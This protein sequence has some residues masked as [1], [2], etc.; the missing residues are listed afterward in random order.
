MAED[1]T[2]RKRAEDALRH[3]EKI[4]ASLLN[5]VPNPIVVTNPDG[6]VRYVNPALE[7]ITGFSSQQV[8][9]LKPPYPWWTEET[10][11]KIS[12]GFEVAFH[13]GARGL[14]ELFQNKNG[15][16]FW[17]EVTSTPVGS[18]GE[19][20]YYL[21]IWVD[22][23]ERKKAEKALKESEKKYKTLYES[24]SDAI[25]LLLPGEK[26]FTGNPAAVKL[27]GCA[28]EEE[29]T[30]Y[31]PVGFS[32]E[33]QPDG[34][35]SIVKAQQ[36]IAIALEKGS[37]F[38][39]WRAKPLKGPE[40]L[41]TISLTKMALGGKIVLQATVRDITDR[42]QAE[43]ALQ[44]SEEKY[45]SLINDVLESSAVGIFILDKEFKIVW[46]NKALGCYFGLQRDEVVGKDIRQLIREGIK[47]IFEDSKLFVEKVFATYDNNAFIEN[48]EC[49][50]VSDDEREERWLEHWS[51]P[52]QSGLYAGGR[53]EHYY[54]ISERKRAEQ[55]TRVLTQKL[56]KA[57]ESER[58][59]ISLYLHDKIAQDLS[60]L[61]I[62]FGSQP[63]GPAETKQTSSEISEVLQAVIMAVR[64]RSY[65]L[66]PPTLD[67]LG[68]VRAAY[69]YCREFSK[70]TGLRVDF[71]SAGMDNTKLDF[72]TD[73]NLYRLIQEGLNNI[74]KH[75]DASRVAVRLVA[76]FPNIILRIEDNGKGFDVKDRLVTAMNEKRMGLWSMEQR[77]SL[78][79]GTMRIQS[80]LT[81]GTRILIDVPYQDK[82]NGSAEK[83]SDH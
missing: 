9:G 14:E 27:F 46:M 83:H 64:D 60:A 80:H 73:I 55:D 56:I 47:D 42:K 25:A 70:K 65:D 5:S 68:L 18:S 10:M 50:V 63:A 40:F 74:K 21:T 23:T 82:R 67:Q 77:V 31:N 69:Q 57:Q 51:Q 15:E 7:K 52:I 66:R 58:Q 1:I 12:E 28:D 43:E 36:M 35:L 6:S 22:I 71:Y 75:A 11:Q 76:S 33:Y 72:D 17:V 26:S 53:I 20:N 3:S 38:F 24:S 45:R 44:K 32:S 54:D 41:C 61:K 49:H 59:R 2:E 78:L 48:F 16:Q 39:E 30:A 19:Y 37:H 8:I 62:S 79:K 4:N 34:T 13:N 81:E 29:F